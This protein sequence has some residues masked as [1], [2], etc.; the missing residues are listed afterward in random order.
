M[1]PFVGPEIGEMLI[2]TGKTA[3]KRSGKSLIGSR[4]AIAPS[5]RK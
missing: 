4:A 2:V 3:G 5:L 1:P